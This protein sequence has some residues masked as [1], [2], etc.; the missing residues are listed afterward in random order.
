LCIY[1]AEDNSRQRAKLT[2]GVK[3]QNEELLHN[4]DLDLQVSGEHGT[5]VV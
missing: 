4:V 2:T 3:E 5:Y 1:F